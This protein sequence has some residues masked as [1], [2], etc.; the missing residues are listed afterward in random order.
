MRSSAPPPGDGNFWLYRSFHLLSTLLLGLQSYI[1]KALV[2]TLLDKYFS[3]RDTSPIALPPPEINGPGPAGPC[4]R[5]RGALRMLGAGF[6]PESDG[7]QV[8]VASAQ[9]QQ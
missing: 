6:P 2:Q 4:N 5:V 8:Q 7:L 1:Y 3:V 9:L